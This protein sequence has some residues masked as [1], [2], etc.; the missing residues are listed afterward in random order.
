M[1]EEVHIIGA[2]LELTGIHARIHARIHV[3]S[4]I[5]GHRFLEERVH[6]GMRLL[7]GHLGVLIQEVHSLRV[8]L[9]IHLVV[10]GRRLDLTRL[11]SLSVGLGQCFLALGGNSVVRWSFLVF[12]TDLVGSTVFIV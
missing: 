6:L 7:L 3:M 11:K 12:G 9:V 5:D 10:L 1:L 2:F 8:D 4:H